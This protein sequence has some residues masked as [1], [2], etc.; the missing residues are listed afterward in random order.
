MPGRERPLSNVPAPIAL[1]AGLHGAVLLARARPWGL[2]LFESTPRGA[3]RSFV[4]VAFC[5]PAYLAIRLLDS[6]YP[7]D[8]GR[9]LAAE[10]IGF[11]LAWAGYAL[12]SF[13]IAASLGRESLWPRFLCAWNWSNVVQYGVM[14]LASV[15]GPLF[16]LPAAVGQTIGLI[17]LGYVLWV[18]WYATRIALQIPGM[19]ATAFVLTDMALGLMVSGLIRR[20]AAGA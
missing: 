10:I 15:P 3:A 13:H 12:V 16:G 4:A 19:G 8:F 20:L 2:L 9:P 6:G 18:E 17:A 14:L 7:A 5:L 11:A 1:L